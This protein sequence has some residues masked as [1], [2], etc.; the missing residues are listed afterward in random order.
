LKARKDVE[1]QLHRH[2]VCRRD[3]RLF[4]I[5]LRTPDSLPVGTQT[6]EAFM[7]AKMH[8]QGQ[9]E[10]LV[11]QVTLLGEQQHLRLVALAGPAILPS[12]DVPIFHLARRDLPGKHP[13]QTEQQ[14]QFVGNVAE[15]FVTAHL[16]FRLDR[17]P[18]FGGTLG[19]QFGHPLWH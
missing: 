18:V 12:A 17:L 5:H 9:P 11:E 4:R 2:A 7:D 1:G 14:L 8:P 19:L 10:E 16:E 3:V 15:F 13:T 6:D